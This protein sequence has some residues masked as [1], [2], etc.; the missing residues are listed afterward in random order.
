LLLSALQTT[1]H[2]NTPFLRWRSTTWLHWVPTLGH[3][4]CGIGS[5]IITF[6]AQTP[7]PAYTLTCGTSLRTCVFVCLGFMYLS[8]VY[9]GDV[10]YA[11]A[12]NLMRGIGWELCGV[13]T[14]P[15]TRE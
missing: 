15:G 1:V 7:C 13:F 12:V 9:Y 10:E 8:D 2:C 6:S 4:E 5:R 3:L 14:L 11:E